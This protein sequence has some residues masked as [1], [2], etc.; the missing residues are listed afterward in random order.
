M[1]VAVVGAGIVG[2]SAALHLARGGHKVQVWE[3]FPLFHD[4]GSSHGRTRIVRRAYPDAFFTELM[5]E[6]YPMWADLESAA[7]IKLVNECGLMY[8][9]LDESPRV[10]EMIAA[11]TALGVRHRV[12]FPREVERIMPAPRLEGGEI[13]VFTPE[14]GEV[15]ADLALSAT[16]ELA[17]ERGVEFRVGRVDPLELAKKTDA[18]VVA[19][20][21]WVRDWVDL[22]ARVTVQT[23]GYVDVPATGPV[24]IDDNT[25]GYGFPADAG[26]AKIG[27]HQ[28]GPEIHP[29]D[30][31]PN[32]D[33]QVAAIR[34]LV[35]RRFGV[36]NCVI[37][38]VATCLYTSFEDEMFRMGWLGDNVLWASSCSGHGFKLG[39][40]VGRTL[41]EIVDGA[42]IPTAFRV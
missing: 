13:G 23:F 4:R 17:L 10:Q 5:T 26:G 19:A 29:D 42:P 21:A 39:P 12:L 38:D 41:A 2:L 9:G 33:E 31:R 20:G 11:L 40:W 34:A 16:H 1:N 3:Q 27:F 22:P 15:Q 32:T 8:F 36:E 25:L 6:A 30:A 28:P 24:W 18:V 14:A 35:K 37:R 7:G